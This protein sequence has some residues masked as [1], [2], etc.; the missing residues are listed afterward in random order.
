MTKDGQTTVLRALKLYFIQ[1]YG[2]DGQAP[3]LP[4]HNIVPNF[5]DGCQDDARLGLSCCLSNARR[6]CLV[7]REER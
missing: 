3:E 5:G 2:S 7:Q 1:T 6:G 4:L